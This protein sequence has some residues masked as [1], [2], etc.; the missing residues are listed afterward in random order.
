[1]KSRVV[2]NQA[3]SVF[4][5]GYRKIE[6]ENGSKIEF[7][8]LFKELINAQAPEI[9]FTEWTILNTGEWSVLAEHEDLHRKI[10]V[11]GK[12]VMDCI[13]KAKNQFKAI[14]ETQVKS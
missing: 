1:M 11:I 13:E 7:A 14:E 5:T 6:T 10:A 3:K 2:E 9:I 8:A 12:S 4:N